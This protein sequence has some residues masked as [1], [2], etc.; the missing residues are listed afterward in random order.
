MDKSLFTVFAPVKGALVPL[1]Q[2]PDPVFSQRMLGD[3][4]AIDP[5]DGTICA[6]FDGKVINFNPNLH[7][8]VLAQQN[9]E[10]LVHV[11][12]DTVQLRGQGFTPLVKV[13]E[14][15]QVGQPILNF[16]LAHVTSNLKVALVLCIV[17]V[18]NQVKVRPVNCEI[19]QV[20]HPLF[21]LQVATASP[22]KHRVDDTVL[23][24]SFTVT[25]S[26]GLHAR[27]AGL[28]ARLCGAYPHP[29]FICKQHS[30]ANAK[31]IIGIMGLAISHGEKITFKIGGPTQEATAFIT[32]L[33]S[34]FTKG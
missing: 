13:G 28:L 18:P 3:G 4:I 21:R 8:F 26:Q 24:A 22:N 19:V 17:T 1:E 6:P 34:F 16:N 7:A 5:A 31:S 25:N 33:Q 29:V 20:G 2:V 11:G 23:S 10:L 15:V 27:P 30:C 12:L 9:I 32:Q 14:T